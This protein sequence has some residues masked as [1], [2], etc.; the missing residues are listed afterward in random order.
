MLDKL[1]LKDKAKKGRELVGNLFGSVGDKVGKVKS[2]LG[3]GDNDNN[4]EKEE[5]KNSEE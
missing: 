5:D 2:L 1:T 3:Q 4:D